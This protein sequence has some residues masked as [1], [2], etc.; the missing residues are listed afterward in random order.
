MSIE[1]IEA[2]LSRPEHARDYLALMEHFALDPM[3]GGEPLAPDV[4][5]RLVP[6]L[7]ERSDVSVLLAYSGGEAVGMALLIESFSSH[8]AKPVW[9]LH[10]MVVHASQ[11]GSGIG[12]RLLADMERRARER[13]YC[14]LTL[15][16]LENNHRAQAVYRKAGWSGYSLADEMGTALFW[17]KKLDP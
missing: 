1:I 4:R 5:E 14:K 15:E 9:N 6:A 10:D 3:A 12:A 16:V 11:R 17:Q 7:L 13:G 8:A 2:D